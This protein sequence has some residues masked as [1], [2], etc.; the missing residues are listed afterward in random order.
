M[1]CESDS[2]LLDRK[3]VSVHSPSPALSHLYHT[4]SYLVAMETS[5]SCWLSEI[6]GHFLILCCPCVP[7]CRP[8]HVEVSVW[9]SAS[10]RRD[11]S[12]GGANGKAA[13]IGRPGEDGE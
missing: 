6:S 5:L 1:N 9:T 4:I 2:V 11:E 3:Y 13:A 10:S 12:R 7:A 8:A